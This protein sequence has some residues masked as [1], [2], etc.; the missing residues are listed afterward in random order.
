MTIVL[1][2]AVLINHLIPPTTTGIFKW[3]E[4]LISK[5]P[6]VITEYSEYLRNERGLKVC[7][8]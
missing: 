6:G 8:L 7:L 2:K 3:V 4:T 5:H 1:S